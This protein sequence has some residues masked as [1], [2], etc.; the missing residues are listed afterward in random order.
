MQRRLILVTGTPRSGTTPVGDT[1]ARAHGT[2]TLYEPLNFHVG[3][4][5]VT[6]YFEV[7]GPAFPPERVDEIVADIRRLRLRLRP[8]VFPS[9]PPLRRLLKRVTGSQTLMTYRKARLD[10]SLRT[11]VWKDPFAAFVAADVAARHHVPVLVTVRPPEAV[12]ASFK[13]LGWGFDVE[14]IVTAMGSGG[15][16]Y[17]DQLQGLDLTDSTHNGIAIWHLVNA[18]L[19]EAA[20]RTPGIRFVDM[21]RV[22]AEPRAS[23]RSMYDDLGLEWTARTDRRL[24]ETAEPAGPAVPAGNRAH[25]GRRDTSS[26]NSYWPEV[27]TEAEVAAAERVNADLWARVRTAAS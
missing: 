11:I 4:R 14:G 1:L 17:R 25:V 16:R 19:L 2:R 22:V 6:R 8:G 9:D 7:P 15:D 5:R 13:R 21:D 10:P 12:A 26:V 20:G 18:V 3:D 24:R 23:Y 27:L